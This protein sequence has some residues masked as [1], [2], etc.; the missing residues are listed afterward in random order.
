MGLDAT[1]LTE[2]VSL[3]VKN[4]NEDVG[5]ANLI[6]NQFV[7]DAVD[8]IFVI[9]TPAA[10]AAM[11]AVDGTD[12][13]V[14]FS[15]VSDAKQA[16]LVDDLAHP[17]GNLTGVSDLPPLDTQVAL[18]QEIM[19]DA[20]NIGILYNTSEINSRNQIDEVRNIAAKIRYEGQ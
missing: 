16:G 10:Q 9:A 6:A 11:N 18:I 1:G 5:T 19:P 13:P 14:I 7:R 2:K 3:E 8:L 17:S 15:A 20:K 12:I 4:A